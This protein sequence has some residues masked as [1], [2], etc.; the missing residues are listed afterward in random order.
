MLFI[1]VCIA[2]GLA[3]LTSLG[4]CWSLSRVHGE[5]G[6]GSGE[7]G[8]PCSHTTQRGQIPRRGC[9]PRLPERRPYACPGIQVHN[10]HATLASR[11]SVCRDII[12]QQHAAAYRLHRGSWQHDVS[13]VCACAPRHT[14]SVPAASTLMPPLHT[15]SSSAARVAAHARERAW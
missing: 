1:A 11:L 13:R 15:H 12:M 10:C 14:T 8:S 7:P 6:G 9:R 5:P 2:A 4:C 3:D